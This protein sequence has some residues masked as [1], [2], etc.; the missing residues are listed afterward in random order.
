[1]N[2][3]TI[4]L[5]NDSDMVFAQRNSLSRTMAQYAWQHLSPEQIENLRTN[6]NYAE[7]W[8]NILVT[9]TFN[10][11]LIR[12]SYFYGLVRIADLEQKMLQ[13]NG[14]NYA[15]GITD[16]TIFNCDLGKNVAIHNVGRVER[17]IIGDNCIIANT[18]EIAVTEQ[19]TFGCGLKSDGTADYI[20]AMNEGG[21]RG[22]AAFT[23]ILPADAY[24]WCKYLYNKEL[25]TSLHQITRAECL[26][27]PTY[28]TIGQGCSIRN[29][30]TIENTNIGDFCTVVGTT[31]MCNTAVKSSAQEPSKIGDG[32]IVED[33]IVG[34][35]CK[36][37]ENSLVQ[38]T[39]LGSN[40]TIEHGARVINTAVSDNSTIA[41]CEVQNSMIFPSHEQH[42]NNSF[43][44]A[45]T[46][47]GQSNIAAGA[48]VGSN[49]NSRSNSGE[50]VAGR[51]FWPG[52]CC[53]FKHSSKFA[54]FTLVA[55]GDYQYELNIPLPFSLINNNLHTNELEVMPAYWWMYNMYALE[56]NNHKFQH[57]DKRAVKRQ[58][59]EY[60][61]LAPDTAEEIITAMR[62][63]EQWTATAWAKSQNLS[64]NDIDKQTIGYKLLTTPPEETEK[65]FI[66]AEGLENS[67]R[68]V[69]ILK[70]AKAY[71]AYAEML[72]Y[73]AVGNIIDYLKIN[74]EVSWESVCEKLY[75]PKRE[76]H[77]ENLGGQLI[78]NSDFEDLCNDI[79]S[80][81]LNS[82]NS[83]H[84]RYDRLW[85][86]YPLQKQRHAYSVLCLLNNTS[87]LTE[88]HWRK[89]LDRFIG[90]LETIERQV[91]LTR[92]KDFDN[93]FCQSTYRNSNEMAACL[94]NCEEDSFVKIT[95]QQIADCKQ[96]IKNIKKHRT[97][98]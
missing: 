83:I 5:H 85:E 90:I 51:G 58:N 69:R 41:C 94:G 48:T 8:N 60:Q 39:I 98:K 38:K 53:S 82:W 88:E 21:Q 43:L 14:L 56:R 33:T 75:S 24:L 93:P 59:I 64:A 45:S 54:S 18:R 4:S 92:K 11:S 78:A 55:K 76:E 28:G 96:F 74:P 80:G 6:G 22:F 62:L 89:S 1:M 13:N 63:L 25:R 46:L 65:L 10:P 70:A 71:K 19:A 61:T 79:V 67:K 12:N 81:K 20:K 26:P 7:D 32:T 29:A 57:R 95:Q 68:T 30:N 9:D 16:C 15:T 35:A 91:L 27:L 97:I 34:Y 66:T 87:S 73:Y 44:I 3:S 84:Q 23:N 2:T 52:L 86:M 77:W 31:K 42:H 40:V 37:L 17:Y 49:H 36:V 50:I 47:L 72:E